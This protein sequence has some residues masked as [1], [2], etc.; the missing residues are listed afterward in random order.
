M[1]IFCSLL[2]LAPRGIFL[3][4]LSNRRSASNITLSQIDLSGPLR[5]RIERPSRSSPSEVQS[6]GSRSTGLFQWPTSTISPSYTLE[7]Y[8][9]LLSRR[10]SSSRSRGGLEIGMAASKLLWWVFDVEGSS[11][12]EWRA[13]ILVHSSIS[14]LI[15]VFRL[16]RTWTADAQASRCFSSLV[17]ETQI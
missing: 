10:A 12:F 7:K 16:S 14:R 13:D 15:P 17:A 3:S 11:P 6:I 8:Q 5:R 1:T 2:A 9:L 4:C